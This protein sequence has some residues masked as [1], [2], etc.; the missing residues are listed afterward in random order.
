MH[1]VGL[2]RREPVEAVVVREGVL[3]LPTIHFPA[4]QETTEQLGA[5]RRLDD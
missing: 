4:G 3:R 2:A 1:P 5:F